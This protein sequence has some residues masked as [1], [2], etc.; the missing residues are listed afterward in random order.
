MAEEKKNGKAK[1][2]EVVSVNIEPLLL[3]L[4]LV[5]SAIIIG[6]SL[7]ISAN[8]LSGKV[9]GTNTGGTATAPTDGANPTND[10]P[11]ATGKSNI[12]DDAIL[13]NRDTAKVAIVEFSDYECPFCKRH[14]V[15]TYPQ[16]VDKYVK[17]GQ[18][19]IVY[20]DFPLSF[21]DPLATTQAMAAECVGEL[22][23]DNK[24]YEY[25]DLIFKNTSSNGNGMQ[26]S[27]LYTMAEQIGIDK[28]QFTTCLDSEKY[29]AEVQKDIADGQASG[30][31]GTPSF[32]IGKFDKNSG[33]VDGVV[34]SG[35]MPYASFETAIEEQLAK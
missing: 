16:I 2:G 24:Y 19:I 34:I 15:D 20:R 25:H 21:H 6:A 13:G 9:L 5:L 14:A 10:T 29:K 27:A 28:G 1:T 30:V 7:I 18:A 12:D 17:S 31:S 11:P 26:K 35:A 4:A 32:V 8:A 22:G 23:G 33:S 3:P